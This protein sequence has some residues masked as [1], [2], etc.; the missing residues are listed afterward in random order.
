MELHS[1]LE[2]P[3]CNNQQPVIQQKLSSSYQKNL[4]Q[5]PKTKQKGTINSQ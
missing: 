2:Y 5:N 4:A 1:N 3:D